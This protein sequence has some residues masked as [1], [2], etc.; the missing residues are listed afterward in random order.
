M[1]LPMDSR[2]KKADTIQVNSLRWGSLV[3]LT[4]LLAGAAVADLGSEEAGQAEVSGQ[5]SAFTLKVERNEVPVRV[6]VRDLQGRPVRNLTKDNFRILDDGKPQ[7]ITQFSTQ[8]AEAAPPA[9]TQT[10]LTAKVADR[11][12]AL[13]FDDLV[14]D[15]DSIVRT[16]DAASKY[17]RTSVQPTDRVAI[18]SSSGKDQL[19]FTN[20]R[21]KLEE[22]LARLRPNGVFKRSGMDCPDLSDYEAFQIDEHHDQQ[23]LAIA[24]QKVIDCRCGGDAQHCPNPETDAQVA[25][26]QRWAEAQTQATYSLRGLEDLV[27][28][29]SVLPGQRVSLSLLGVRG[30]PCGAVAQRARR[31]GVRAEVP[32]D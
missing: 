6:I 3:L 4:A 22:A 27:R 5:N 19:D 12:V 13:Y 15:F 29:L 11:F 32:P 20:D 26:R 14:M 7:V 17:L 16:R 28:R 25:A 21:D 2:N 1:N 10:A 8:G 31:G 30:H 9:E 24:T 18:F 23:A